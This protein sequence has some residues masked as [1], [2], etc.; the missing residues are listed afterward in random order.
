MKRIIFSIVTVFFALALFTGCAAK[1][2]MSSLT[3]EDKR[4]NMESFDYIWSTIKE[5]HW[6]P[7]MNGVDWD[8]LK[9]ELRPKVEVA[10]SKAE[11]RA[12]MQELIGSLGQSHFA[13]FSES[14][15]KGIK[16]NNED[17]NG[18]N[19]EEDSGLPDGWTGITTRVID[20]EAVV[21]SVE[22]D[23]PADKAGV[24]TG[25]IVVKVNDDK[26]KSAMKEVA[27]EFEDPKYKK[28]VLSFVANHKLEGNK[29]ESI[30]I[31]FKNENNKKTE[32]ELIF[33][34]KKGDYVVFGNLPPMYVW[35]ETRR[36]DS[37]IGYIAFNSFMNPG[38]LMTKY[39]NAMMEFM[40]AKGLII[41]L[42]GNGGGI[43]AMAMGM[44]GWLVDKEEQHLGTV[45]MKGTEL[46]LIV[47]PRPIS[48]KGP[49]AVLVDGLS[50]SSSEFLA[51]GLQDIGRAKVFGDNT[52][53]A[54]LPSIIERLPNGDGFQYAIANYISAG[55]E[56]LE[57]KGVIPDVE[58]LYS[59]ASLLEGKDA[60]LD[61]AVSWIES[62]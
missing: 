17:G 31:L 16:N 43:A 34:E 35:I 11:A 25:W 23:S 21:I 33:C 3:P 30:K 15:Y 10:T 46:K 32:K 50:G 54:A 14:A 4:L 26:I 37:N 58:V 36:L 55:G 22:K 57:G 1:Q 5:K 47:Y 6:D 48:F 40:D 44:S 18:D 39:N 27:K 29:G 51:G 28:A 7:E 59:R 49:V 62:Q 8:G 19:S 56:A 38:K 9:K 12:V 41:D 60:I 20:G 45:Y 24:K 53:G 13:V 52:I 42:R 61:S 2:K